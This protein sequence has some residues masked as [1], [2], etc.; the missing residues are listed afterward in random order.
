[1]TEQEAIQILVNA[2]TPMSTALDV[3]G[4]IK[5][6]PHIWKAFQKH[7]LEIVSQGAKRLGAKAVFEHMRY[8]ESGG[9]WEKY[10]EFKISNDYTAYFARLL[11]G[12]YPNCKNLFVFKK[13]KG[14]ER[15]REQYGRL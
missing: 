14:L 9:D 2:G 10:D 6:Y 7:C 8:K 1:M 5:K 4:Y 3:C 13:I 15:A 11:A 12:K